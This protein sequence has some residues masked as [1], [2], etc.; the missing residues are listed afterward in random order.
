MSALLE[1]SETQK[2]V[3]VSSS[4]SPTV[5]EL[6]PRVE[7]C[8]SCVWDSSYAHLPQHHR[9]GPWVLLWARTGGKRCCGTAW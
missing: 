9:K 2:G 1:H 3:W 7:H 6:I 8:C 4:L 5:P